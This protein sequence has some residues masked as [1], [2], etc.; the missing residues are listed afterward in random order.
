M[1]PVR[2]SPSPASWMPWLPS[3]SPSENDT[4]RS[5]KIGAAL[6][7]TAGWIRLVARLHFEGRD[8][9]LAE[10]IGCR[11]YNCDMPKTVQVIKGQ[12]D[13]GKGIGER[14]IIAA[15]KAR[16]M[17]TLAADGAKTD[18]GTVKV[19]VLAIREAVASARV[20]I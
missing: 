8:D 7:S 3:S 6:D 13:S 16:R 4:Q 15:T 12:I 2:L 9:E 5:D 17:N 1:S 14:T 20:G 10:A 18:I 19:D 11:N